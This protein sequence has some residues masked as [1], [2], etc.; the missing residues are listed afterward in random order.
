[1]TELSNEN[2]FNFKFVYMIPFYYSGQIIV[3]GK[4]DISKTNLSH[5]ICEESFDM[6]YTVFDIGIELSKDWG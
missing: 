4:L 5:N 1:M 6:V 2:R 3:E